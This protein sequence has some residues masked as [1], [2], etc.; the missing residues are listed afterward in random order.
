MS[1]QW[2]ELAVYP[3]P[4][5]AEAV[6]GLLR[7]E[8][9]PARVRSDEP[10]P[11]LLKGCAVLVPAAMLSRAQTVCSQA[12]MSDEEWSQYAQDALAEEERSKGTMK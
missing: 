4:A 6:A 11:G 2:R 8:S 7:S 10:V 3:D 12:Q 5:S 9:I 1:D